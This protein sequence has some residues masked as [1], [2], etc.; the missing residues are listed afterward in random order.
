MPLLTSGGL[1]LYEDPLI[2][3]AREKL[4]KPQ[5]IVQ[6]TQDRIASTLQGLEQ[7]MGIAPVVPV[8][9][10][11]GATV[12]LAPLETERRQKATAN[13]LALVSGGLGMGAGQT[14]ARVNNEAITAPEGTLLARLQQERGR[15]TEEYSIEG[16]I[17]PYSVGAEKLTKWLEPYTEAAGRAFGDFYG[18]TPAG[19]FQNK[20]IAPA[21][22]KLGVDEAGRRVAEHSLP[23]LLGLPNAAVYGATEALTSDT[24][25][26]GAAGGK[27]TP[28]VLIPQ[29]EWQALA[30]LP[31]LL[32][33]G[34]EA[35]SR[36]LGVAGRNLL[37]D[38]GDVRTASK[39]PALTGGA[40]VAL[41]QNPASVGGE[42]I[43]R[44]GDPLTAKGLTLAGGADEAA[45]AATKVDIAPEVSKLTEAINATRK[46]PGETAEL[47]SKALKQRVAVSASILEKGG[48]SPQAYRRATGALGG[49]LPKASFEAPMLSFSPNEVTALRSKLATSGLQHFEELNAERALNNVLEGRLADIRPFELNLL[50]RVYGRELAASIADKQ[51]I[52]WW[53]EAAGV[54]SLPQTLG[55][56]SDLSAPFRQGFVIAAAHPKEWAASWG[57]MIKAGLSEDKARQLDDALRATPW[58][59]THSNPEKAAVAFDKV[60]GHLS[61]LGV[62]GGEAERESGR[63]FMG[64]SRITNAARRVIPTVRPSERAYTTNLNFMRAKVYATEAEKLWNVGVRD[65]KQYEAMAKVINHASGW[66]EISFGQISAG[67]TGINT[68]FAPRLFASRIQVALDPFVQPGSLFQPSARQLA[69][70]QLV[71]AATIPAS[72]ITLAGVA[73]GAELTWNPI[74]TDFGKLKRGTQ[75]V[76]LLGG[77]SPM[78]RFVARMA[79]GKGIS[80]SGDPYDVSSP[81]ER[82]KLAT[83]FLRG[84]ESPVA[85][86][87][88]DIFTGENMIG[89]K[90]KATPEWI[91][92][93]VREM[94]IPFFAQDVYEA[95]RAEGLEGAALALPGLVGGTVMTYETT[96]EKRNQ[97]AQEAY[98]KPYRDLLVS[99]QAEINTQLRE[100]GDITTSEMG[101][102]REKVSGEIQAEQDQ[103]ETAFLEG[104]N[105]RPLPDEWHDFNQQRY[106]ARSQYAEDFKAALEGFAKDDFDKVINGYYDIEMSRA[107][108]S[109][110]YE[111]TNQAREEYVNRLSQS[112]AK[113]GTPSAFDYMNDYLG[114]VE[115]KKSPFE[116]EYHAFLNEREAQ[117][118]TPEMSTKD[119]ETFWT[120][121]P[122][123]EAQQAFW[124]SY[125]GKPV[126]TLETQE[127]IDTFLVLN[128]QYGTPYGAKL[129]GFDFVV[130]EN[131]GTMAAWQTLYPD[132]ESYFNVDSSKR[133]TWLKAHPAE[134]AALVFLGYSTLKLQ[135]KEAQRRLSQLVNQYG[136]DV[137]G[138]LAEG[139]K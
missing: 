28:S 4:L 130:N 77:F 50:D 110:D 68:F 104:L 131:E 116:Q 19:A 9:T 54:I 137:T 139:A 23:G 82:L 83:D 75:R 124:G 125:E 65:V 32:L 45:E 20:V 31:G 42:A 133:T 26:I 94:F 13:T 47:R 122:G 30:A 107:D 69:A 5:T 95:A 105:S 113:D 18:A 89:E 86:L 97:L 46:L 58:V 41:T 8:T 92:N 12:D 121:H 127:A 34:G 40:K 29:N 7:R 21:L 48:R 109:L 80:S 2:K 85:S 27:T 15:G 66:S 78:V 96:G 53:E 134:N 114:Y 17:G 132:V 51:P 59:T 43:V 44:Q 72:L 108:G 10:R 14:Q 138:E 90:T 1:Q 63:A 49:A 73:A 87:L 84:K 120:E 71:A 6:P 38:V 70:K 39:L 64:R 55:A 100:S 111:A 24:G 126:A 79:Q 37:G 102:P 76:D 135:T 98:G 11:S 91:S 136:I 81:E 60:G 22:D 123:L 106:G 16:G 128:Q 35:S 33:F 93:R 119:A 25:D 117:G 103:R 99:E 118:Y 115:G 3:K 67:R 56:S 36:G 129:S 52:D 112:A 62:F 61:D 57:P 88:T 101:L 74:D